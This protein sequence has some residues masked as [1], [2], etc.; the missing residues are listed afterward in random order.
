MNQDNMHIVFLCPKSTSS[1]INF[2]T[3]SNLAANSDDCLT[4]ATSCRLNIFELLV[5]FPVTKHRNKTR[6]KMPPGPR[7]SKHQADHSNVEGNV[8]DDG[9]RHAQQRL[10]I[11]LH[12]RLWPARNA[13]WKW[14]V[15]FDLLEIFAAWALSSTLDDILFLSRCLLWCRHVQ[16]WGIFRRIPEIGAAILGQGSYGVVSWPRGS[17]LIGMAYAS[18]IRRVKCYTGCLCCFKFGPICRWRLSKVWAN[19]NDCLIGSIAIKARD[20][21]PMVSHINKFW[22]VLLVKTLM[23]VWMP[24]WRI[25]T[26]HGWKYCLILFDKNLANPWDESL[27]VWC[28]MDEGNDKLYAVKNICEASEWGTTTQPWVLQKPCLTVWVSL[29]FGNLSTPTWRE[30]FRLFKT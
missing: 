13:L 14:T 26:G 17:C 30:L 15:E 21:E 5:W 11:L 23:N 3:A 28:A 25:S 27:Q 9:D 12:S 16:N 8:H 20:A 7:V 10:F 18:T 6:S 19:P 22:E 2:S 1:P 24:S 29:L 4:Q